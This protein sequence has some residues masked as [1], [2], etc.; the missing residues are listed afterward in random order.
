MT[1]M[2]TTT[3]S[4]LHSTPDWAIEAGEKLAARRAARRAAREA[5]ADAEDGRRRVPAEE[6]Q[7][8]FASTV[9]LVLE[10]LDTFATAAGLSIEAAPPSAT[11]LELRVGDELLRLKRDD[12]AL[13]VLV[14]N[15]SRSNE[16]P[17]DLGDP[18]APTD[19]A[20]RIAQEWMQRLT[21]AEEGR[22]AQ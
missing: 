16:Y 20:R 8:R 10:A 4:D 9:A 12:D 3:A 2:T 21:T 15:R 19:T 11:Q 6:L 5:E 7:Q 17:V 13:V 22:H 14:R 18:F 1:I